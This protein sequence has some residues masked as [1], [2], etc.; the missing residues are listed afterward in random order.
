MTPIF[1]H[2]VNMA[3]LMILDG[4]KTIIIGL[5][6]D[7]Q[8]VIIRL[9]D[10][11]HRNMAKLVISDGIK[12]TFAKIAKKFMIIKSMLQHFLNLQK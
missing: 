11:H 1:L 3:K 8:T 4:Y 10:G 7:Y 12:G 6:N 9:S 2:I 5:L